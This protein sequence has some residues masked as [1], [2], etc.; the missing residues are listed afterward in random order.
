M[1]TITSG[2]TPIFL[3]DYNWTQLFLFQQYSGVAS[4]IPSSGLTGSGNL[5]LDIQHTGDLFFGKTGVGFLTIFTGPTGGGNLP[6]IQYCRNTNRYSAL[7]GFSTSAFSLDFN[8]QRSSFLT[9]SCDGV[10]SRNLYT[11]LTGGGNLPPSTFCVT[12]YINNSGVGSLYIY[13]GLTA[14]KYIKAIAIQETCSFPLISCTDQYTD[15]HT[16]YFLDGVLPDPRW[17]LFPGDHTV[18]LSPSLL[19][20]RLHWDKD[21]RWLAPWF[22]EWHIQSTVFPFSFC[23]LDWQHRHDPATTLLFAINLFLIWLIVI[24]GSFI[25]ILYQHFFGL[26]ALLRDIPDLSAPPVAPKHSG[27]PGPKSRGQPTAWHSS[28]RIFHIICVFTLGFNCFLGLVRGEGC[29]LVMEG[30]EVSHSQQPMQHLP[31][32]TKRH[33]TRPETCK[34]AAHWPLKQRQRPVVKRSI[35]RAY[36]RALQQGFSW[37]KGR[38]YAPTDFPYAL[39][40]N[41]QP[42][43]SPKPAQLQPKPQ[44]NWKHIDKARFRVLNWNAGGLSAYRL[45]ELKVWMQ[46]Q[47]IEAA[48]IT[49][50][51]WKFESTWS[52]PDFHYVHTGDQQHAGQGILC[53]LAK[54]FCSTDQ[55]KW[56]VI[57]PGRLVHIQVQLDRRAIDLI[58]CYQH[59]YAATTQRQSARTLLWDQLDQLLHGLV[60]RNILVLGGDFNCDLLQAASHSGPEVFHWRGSLTRGAQHRDNGR[61]TSLVRLHGLVALNTWT[62]HLGPTYEHANACSRI[63]FII[64]RKQVADGISKDV[65]YARDAP[66]Q[67]E[68]GHVPMIAQLRKQWF[69][70]HQQ[71]HVWGVTPSQRRQG[72]IA[73]R[74]NTPEWQEFVTQT[75]AAL[76]DTLTSAQHSDDDVIP[77]MHRVAIECFQSHFPTIP[78]KKTTPD[79][80]TEHIVMTKWQHRRALQTLTQVTLPTLFQA[81]MHQTKFAQLNRQSKQHAKTVRQQRFDEVLQSAQTAAQRHDSHAL[82]TIINKYSP[83]QS[84]RKIQLRNLQGNIASPIEE[85]AMLKKHIMDTWKGPPTFPTMPYPHSGMPFTADELEAEMSRIPA[86][87]AV[88]RPCALGT[89]WRALA[90]QLAPIIH[91][92][93][94]EWWNKPEPFLPGWFRDSWMI[95]IP[96]PNKPPVSP[97]VLRPLALQEPISKCIV[98]LL[99][100]KAL[101]DAMPAFT[102]MPLWAYLPGRSTQDALLRVGHHC[103]AVRN[104]MT[105]L[106]STPFTRYRGLNRH[107]IAGGLQLFLD[108]EK[109]FD[110]VSRAR[111]FSRLGEIGINPQIVILLSHWHQQT[112][113]HLNSNG[114]DIPI[115]V[116]RGVRQGCR[117]APLLWT[118][119]MWLF[120]LELSRVTN[121][122]WVANCVNIFADDCHMG[123]VFSTNEDLQ[124]LVRNI[125]KTLHLIKRFGLT[126]NP[127]KCTALLRMGGTAHR[128]TRLTLTAWRDGKEWIGFTSDTHD[129]IWIPLARQAK[130]L[131][132]VIS[133]TTWEDQTV[134]HRVQLSK[135]AFSRLRRWLTGKRGLNRR[136]RLQLFTTCVYPVM[137]YGVFSLGLTTFGMQ[138]INK[139]MFSMLRQILGDHAYI[140]GHSH[141]AALQ[142]N[143]VA[144][145]LEWLLNSIDSLQRSLTCRLA[146]ATHTDIIRQLDWTHLDSLRAQ[147]QWHLCTGPAVPVQTPEPEVHPAL[148]QCQICQY[149]TADVAQFR[150]HC[151]MMHDHRMNRCFPAQHTDYMLHGLPQCKYCHQKFA[152]WRNFHVHIQRGCQVLLAGP[153]ECWTD[154]HRSLASDPPQK[155][156][157]FAAKLDGPVRGDAALTDADLANLKHQEWGTRVLTIVATRAW[158]H[159]RKE[160]DACT[161]LASRCCLCDQFLG[162]TQELH[163][164]LKIHHPEF[165]PHVQAKGIQLSNLYGEE[166]PCPFCHALFKSNHQCPIWVQLGLL[167]VYGGG[168]HE[169]ATPSQLA[170]RCEICMEHFSSSET[171]HNHLVQ[172]HRLSNPSFNPARDTLEGEPVCAHCLTMYDNVESLRSHIVQGRC[173]NFNADLPTEVVDVQPRWIAALCQGQL[174]NT[175]RDPHVRMELTL[176]CQNCKSRYLRA[177]DLSGHLLAAHPKLWSAAQAVTGLLVELLYDETGCLCNPNIGSHRSHHVC[178]PLRQL[179]MQFMRMQEP[180]LYPHIPTEEELTLL[181]SSRLDREARFL[182]ERAI[183]GN[184]IDAHWKDPALLTLL[185]STCVLCGTTMHPAELVIH[186]F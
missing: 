154:P 2:P 5:P 81:W 144:L 13:S 66:F 103:L 63:D 129:I 35:R 53:I 48:I 59:T 74:L 151:T 17:L 120:L 55:L 60:A 136:Q 106:R 156:D 131:G 157:M 7:S 152:S 54:H 70:P 174:A 114:E 18:D 67:G 130:Y 177:S 4:R 163:R 78:R 186:L 1:T 50:T 52:D 96:K 146:Q 95:L 170:Q 141:Q 72:H 92:F 61:F 109:A 23:L 36:A 56:R 115:A 62:P 97:S 179:G 6:P 11:G 21:I 87:R 47:C 113:Y 169:G 137:T 105:C 82:F 85:T 19:R 22:S 161:Y 143:S 155:P 119:Y 90:P 16:T 46:H 3:L 86:S 124:T 65:L 26:A 133:Y 168:T 122:S 84:K 140:T 93:L 12:G 135:I 101:W 73:S 57:H 10:G 142:R 158:H 39:R 171:L 69:A 175:L 117:A 134:R 30:A 138:H 79:A 20:L 121:P 100:K 123:D 118:G 166:T 28:R 165:W 98:G 38:C 32:D 147:I 150:R 51:R 91:A 77:T 104:M 178:L 173:L 94:T 83:K 145:P 15:Q 126:I 167:L 58:G 148:H 176:Q 8:L 181:Y 33:D 80:I 164:H 88:A 153:A 127:A 89:V 43:L 116:G 160:S 162:R 108:I 45:D 31:R 49:E 112:H 71:R 44:S 184:S 14:N 110:T 24:I 149:Q 102:L 25:A 75:A 172:E 128:K 34:I 183:T 180:I 111:L 99:T 107:R 27:S 125:A 159:M 37:Y 182:L 42:S 40:E 29:T 41:Y 9:E 139:N 76:M 64:T 68:V 185:R 132:T